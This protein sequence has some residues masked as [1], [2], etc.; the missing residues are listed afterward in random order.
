MVWCRLKFNRTQCHSS[1]KSSEEMVFIAH[2]CSQFFQRKRLSITFLLQQVCW[3]NFFFHFEF[4]SFIS[5]HSI[6]T[7]GLYVESHGVTDMDVYDHMLNKTIKYSP[8]MFMLRPNVTPIWTLNELAG[9]HSA[10]FMWLAGDFAFRG[11][12]PTYFQPYARDMHWQ[13]QID[14]LIPM[15]KRNESRMNFVMFYI[16]HPD[17]ESHLYSVPSKEVGR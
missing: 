1:P 12:K 2:N 14:R 3:N 8:E 16:N 4:F 6:C 17:A 7:I 10:V 9:G 13:S 15:L 5:F 11:I